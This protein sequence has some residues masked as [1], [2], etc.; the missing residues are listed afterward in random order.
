MWTLCRKS[1]NE[2]SPTFSSGAPMPC[3]LT[4]LLFLFIPVLQLH[5]DNS[6][7]SWRH[8]P[9]PSPPRGPSWK[10]HPI[11][12]SP[13]SQPH[14][15]A[16]QLIPALADKAFCGLPWFCAPRGDLLLQQN[17]GS[18]DQSEAPDP[19]QIQASSLLALRHSF[20]VCVAS[21]V[22]QMIKNLPAMWE[23]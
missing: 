9:N 11:L 16:V 2:T 14:T 19:V 21:L 12:L 13:S 7:L 1:E 23:T 17:W 18:V 6:Y 5:L 22:A 3:P 20:L 10:F 4:L 15:H 8:S